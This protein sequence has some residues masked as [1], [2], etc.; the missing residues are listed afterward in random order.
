MKH[1][2]L[3]LKHKDESR[4]LQEGVIT[5]TMDKNQRTY[6]YAVLIKKVNPFYDIFING[7]FIT[8]ASTIASA[9]RRAKD[10]IK[11]VRNF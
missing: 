5:V 3:I 10:Y 6:S 1:Y 2:K 11:G 7:E 4:V 8:K 9:K